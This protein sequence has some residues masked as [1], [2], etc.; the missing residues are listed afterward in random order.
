M[1]LDTSS[2]WKETS[3]HRHQMMSI[4]NEL[5]EMDHY[6][7][8]AISSSSPVT[9]DTNNLNTLYI[10]KRRMKPHGLKI[11]IQR[12]LVSKLPQSIQLH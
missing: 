8:P 1:N 9:T 11:P 3:N 6:S 12:I 10:P 4:H 5:R 2:H 7:L